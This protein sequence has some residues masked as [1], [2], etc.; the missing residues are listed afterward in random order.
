ML[1]RVVVVPVPRD[2]DPG[3]WDPVIAALQIHL[4]IPGL[5]SGPA[6]SGPNDPIRLGVLLKLRKTARIFPIF[7]VFRWNNEQ[8]A[9]GEMCSA[10]F[11]KTVNCCLGPGRHRVQNK[12]EAVASTGS[13][14]LHI[15][16]LMHT[17]HARRAKGSFS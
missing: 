16:V 1:P 11:N 7:E 12:V 13:G 6:Y 10:N 5:F 8:R 15:S 2:P 14:T 9:R 4:I 3:P 17:K